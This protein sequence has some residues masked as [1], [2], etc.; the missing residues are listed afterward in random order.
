MPMNDLER[1]AL[2]SQLSDAERTREHAERQFDT[3]RNDVASCEKALLDARAKLLKW[4]AC[5]DMA[6]RV[7]NLIRGE[8]TSDKRSSA[9]HE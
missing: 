7:E 3:A 9:K 6:T 1:E 2:A 8:L 4:Q 5:R